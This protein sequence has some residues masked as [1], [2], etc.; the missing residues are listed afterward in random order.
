MRRSKYASRSRRPSFAARAPQWTKLSGS[1]PALPKPFCCST[2]L[3]GA[4]G[5]AIRSPRVRS[6]RLSPHS[7]SLRPQWRAPTHAE[8]S[9]GSGVRK[10][11]G[12]IASSLL[13]SAHRV[14]RGDQLLRRFVE[15]A[16]RAQIVTIVNS[17]AS[18]T[19]LGELFTAELCE[20]LEA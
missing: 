18:E 14:D 3:R 17:A 10:E 9:G 15:A 6:S 19:E 16:R 2:V 11:T 5:S 13:H 8:R 20:A 7:A 12:T 1:F 4:H